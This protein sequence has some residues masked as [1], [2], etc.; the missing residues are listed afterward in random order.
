[1]SHRRGDPRP[2]PQAVC[3][4][5]TEGRHRCMRAGDESEQARKLLAS[6]SACGHMHERGHAEGRHEI[7]QARARAH[8]HLEEGRAGTLTPAIARAHAR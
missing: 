7:A 1:M 3:A 8:R 5:I 6:A 4:R 2:G